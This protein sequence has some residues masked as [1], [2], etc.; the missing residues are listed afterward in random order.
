MKRENVA[1]SYMIKKLAKKK[2]TKTKKTA[3][4]EHF[5]LKIGTLMAMSHRPN[6]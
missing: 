6:G 1:K 4:N 2:Q 3:F 5:W